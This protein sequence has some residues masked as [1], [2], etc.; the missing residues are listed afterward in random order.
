MLQNLNCCPSAKH[1][2]IAK[3]ATGGSLLA[4]LPKI[5][6]QKITNWAKIKSVHCKS[7]GS[8]EVKSA[9]CHVKTW[10]A[11]KLVGDMLNIRTGRTK[12]FG[13]F[14]TLASAKLA[15]PGQVIANFLWPWCMFVGLSPV[16]HLWQLCG[17][18]EQGNLHGKTR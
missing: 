2:K 12:Y 1:R 5:A 3:K 18:D 16:A 9:Y 11:E 17:R 6:A 14:T 13:D 10:K 4:A 15:K 8:H 7:L